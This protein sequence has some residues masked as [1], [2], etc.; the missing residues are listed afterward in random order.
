[1][2]ADMKPDMV[3]SDIEQ[4]YSMNRADVDPKNMQELTLYVSW[5]FIWTLL[6]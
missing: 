2:S 3:D 1:M 5:Y 4:S 6:E